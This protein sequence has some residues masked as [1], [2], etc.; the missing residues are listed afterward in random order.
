MGKVAKTANALKEVTTKIKKKLPKTKTVKDVAL[1]TL[2]ASGAA[3]TAYGAASS[4][5]DNKKNKDLK[6][7][8]SNSRRARQEG[9]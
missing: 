2:G 6:P 5:S 4:I 8:N 9:K 1:E 3:L 7:G